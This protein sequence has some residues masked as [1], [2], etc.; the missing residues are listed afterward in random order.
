MNIEQNKYIKESFGSG[1]DSFDLFD[2][3]YTLFFIR[4]IL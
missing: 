4:T 1:Y 3:I 2:P